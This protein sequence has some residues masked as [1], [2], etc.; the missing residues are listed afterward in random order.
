MKMRK[1]HR[2]PLSDRA[3][4]ILDKLPRSGNYIFER[5]GKPLN[6]KAVRR[7]LETMGVNDGATTHG[8]RS[9]MRDWGAEI[10]D[11]PNELLE[12]ALA[13]KVSDKTEAAYRRG[14]MLDKRRKLMADWAAFLGKTQKG[15]R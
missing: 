5:K 9:S 7:L 12:L 15:S 11:Y 3:L 10:G 4:A 2:Q 6:Q 13:H 14:S 8:F 1:E